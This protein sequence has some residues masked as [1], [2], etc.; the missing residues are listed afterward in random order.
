M[1]STA[2]QL[3]GEN[4]IGRKCYNAYHGRK[5]RCNKCAIAKTFQD[6]QVHEQETEAVDTNGNRH[7]LWC[8]SVAVNYYQ[9]RTVKT[10]LEVSR[11]ITKRKL[12]EIELKKS[13][14][15]LEELNAALKVLLRQREEDKK[16]LENRIAS[17][18]KRLVIP[19]IEKMKGNYLDPNQLSNL[20]ILETNLNEIVSPFL[21]NIRQFNLTPRETQIAALIKDGKTTKEI[22]L[23]IGL[24]TSSVDSYRNNIRSK[25]GLNKKRVNLL[26]YLQSIK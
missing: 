10:V 12:A 24:G 6:A 4:C 25:L 22:A 14:E 19:Y 5:S 1:N 11:D 26:S 20:N 23:I 8:T 18:V 9:D 3:F 13:K 17:N 21:Q 16:D 15:T 2:K 7:Y